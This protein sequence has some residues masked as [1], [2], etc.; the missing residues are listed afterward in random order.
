MSGM[1]LEGRGEMRSRGYC[2]RL[3][4]LCPSLVRVSAH[5]VMSSTGRDAWYPRWEG[6]AD[7]LARAYPGTE[8]AAAGVD[9]DRIHL[10]DY[11]Y[12]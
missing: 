4:Y 1:D 11:Y 12:Y 8:E 3:Y 9:D 2:F 5:P 6:E 7:P 10:C